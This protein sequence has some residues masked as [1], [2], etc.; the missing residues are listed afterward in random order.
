LLE[1][2]VLVVEPS[3]SYKTA[4]SVTLVGDL[5]LANASISIC[6][7][8]LS[9]GPIWERGWVMKLGRPVLV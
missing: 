4:R 5:A 8:R 7:R 2:S 1:V 3:D 6:V 9:E